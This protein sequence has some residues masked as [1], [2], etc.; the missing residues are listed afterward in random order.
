MSRAS[1]GRPRATVAPAWIATAAGVAAFALAAAPL[2]AQST[3]PRAEAERPRA[4]R[5]EVQVGGAWSTG[6][7]LGDQQALLTQN[8]VPAG[9]DSPLFSTT[10]ELGG[11]PAFDGRAGFVVHPEWRV[12]AGFSYGQPEL[13]TTISGDTEQPAPAVAVDRFD[14]YI[15]DGSVVWSP[16]RWRFGGGRGVPFVLG[17]AGYLRQLLSERTV[18]ETGLTYHVGGGAAWG[19]GRPSPAGPRWG[20]NTEARLTWRVG[21]V[22]VEDEVRMAP[23]FG[24]GVFV[25]F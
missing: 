25:R 22:D 1:S 24:A 17:G 13:R 16:R 21:G 6:L 4:P 5:F 20:V 19:M 8:G 11:A 9:G 12:V 18:I 7:G 23:R 2:N 3:P 14:E 15:V 10:T